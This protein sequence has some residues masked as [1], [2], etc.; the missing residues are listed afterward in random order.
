MYL[1]ELIKAIIFGIV[2]G[3]TE[4]LPI[5]STG[6]L[7]LLD[8][9]LKLDVAPNLSADFAAAYWSFFEVAI[10][11][12][13]ILAVVVLFWHKIWPFSKKKTAQ[14]KKSTW[15]LLFKVAVASI[16]AAFIGIV[17]DK[18][19]EKITS[20]D[21]EG[22]LYNWQ[23]VA[24]A[25]IVYGIAFIFIEK[26]LAKRKSRVENVEDISFLQ[27]IFAGCFQAL[28]IIPGT[29]RSGSTILG[30]RAMGFS[31][32]AAAE[33]SFL[34]GIVAMFGASLIKGADFASYVIE[35]SISIPAL[36]IVALVLSAA[37][38][39][40]VSIVSIRFLMDFIKKH[41]FVP[42]GI[43]RIILGIVVILYFALAR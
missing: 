27:A 20:K 43:Y 4:W 42:F 32:T 25:L 5:S 18:I 15:A 10:Q 34:M 23:T 35:N 14:E 22:W 12:G 28:S 39:F 38:A 26:L 17:F 21:I 16:P 30:S 29:S 24:V 6:H 40:V 37:V 11:L 33:F 2:E 8:E 3:I 36:A 7:I 31:R 9:F 19:L 13:A 41:S 1:W